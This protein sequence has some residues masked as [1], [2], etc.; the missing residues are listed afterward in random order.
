MKNIVFDAGPVIT[1]TLNEL[2]WLLD[3]LKG[4]YN[5]FFYIPPSVKE[6]LINKPLRTKKYA[7]EAIR[8]MDKI[9]EGTLTVI[10]EKRIIDLATKLSDLANNSFSMHDRNLTIV[11]RGEMES[12]AAA[13]LLKSDAV[14]IDERTTRMLV[15]EPKMLLKILIKKFHKKIRVNKNTLSKFSQEVRGLKIIRSAEL[16]TIAFDLGLLD[17][18]IT[19]RGKIDPQMKKTLLESALW[20]VKLTGC[21]ISRK[22]IDEIVRIETKK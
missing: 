9:N 15:E 1:L 10:S 6:E 14:V 7:F 20:A 5:G 17:E 8:V 19:A 11:Q 18:Y 12:V 16:V 13:I 4:R 22:N 2:L 3:E 21:A